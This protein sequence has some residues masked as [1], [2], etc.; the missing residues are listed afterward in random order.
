MAKKN[1][2]G[3]IVAA[4]LTAAACTGAPVLAQGYPDKPITFVVP[5][6]PGASTDLLARSVA[7]KMSES[8][9]QPI[10]VENRSGAGGTIGSNIVARAAPDGY[11][12]VLGSG[13]S[14]GIVK[15]TIK[16]LPYD[17]VK[18]FTAPP[19]RSSRRSCWRCTPRCW[20]TTRGSSSST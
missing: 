6:G 13:A 2:L 9:G 3:T 8:M 14:H 20:R 7:Q 15:F 11:T 5:Y 18:D 12:I 19:R 16:A 1:A 4:V 17:P 10:L